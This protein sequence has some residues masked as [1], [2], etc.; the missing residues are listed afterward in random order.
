MDDILERQKLQ[1]E[2]ETEK[3][4]LGAADFKRSTDVSLVK[5]ACRVTCTS[6]FI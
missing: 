3:Q 6:K 4:K 5:E 1:R 2:R